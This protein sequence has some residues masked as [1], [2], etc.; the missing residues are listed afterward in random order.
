MTC[1]GN[2]NAK[3]Y[4]FGKSLCN[5]QATPAAPELLDGGEHTIQSDLY[6]LGCVFHYLLT[7][8]LPINS[9]NFEQTQHS[10]SQVRCDL[11]PKLIHWINLLKSPIPEQRPQNCAD[12][13]QKLAE[14]NLTQ[15]DQEF[16]VPADLILSSKSSRTVRPISV[17]SLTHKISD[18][19]LTAQIPS[20]EQDENTP[21][22]SNVH[23]DMPPTNCEVTHAAEW[24]FNVK[25]VVKGPLELEQLQH[26]CREGKVQKSHL[27][28]HPYSGEWVKAEN[29]D[30]ITQHLA[31]PQKSLTRLSSRCITKPSSA[32][33]FRLL[34]PNQ[35]EKSSI[36]CE[37]FIVL[38]GATATAAAAYLSPD[39]LHLIVAGYALL[40]VLA[41]LLYSKIQQYKS[42]K[43][44]LAL[45]FLFP[46]VGDLLHAIVR[47]SAK[48]TLGALMLLTGSIYLGY[49][50]MNQM[51]SLS[52]D[53]D[54]VKST[55]LT[56]MITTSTTLLATKETK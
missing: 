52:Q 14:I 9:D 22:S 55:E 17:E 11:E 54:I 40:L 16:T 47:P 42:G 24:F 2:Y 29:C 46:L 8:A 39:S 4:G 3:L 37:L 44:W 41:G 30:E 20:V 28:W 6:A 38:T 50:S 36:F 19:S 34:G 53:S 43:S 51:N 49:F 10:L 15:N 56:S 27:I 5:S 26:L 12:A 25:G 33:Q 48:S 7:G 13:I 32:D 31:H 1:E 23:L 45:C 18:T 21:T 35:G